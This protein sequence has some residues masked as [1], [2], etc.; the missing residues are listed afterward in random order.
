MKKISTYFLI[1]ITTI[2]L[3][4]QSL[5]AQLEDGSIAEDWTL[6]DINGNSWNL[7]SLLNQNISVFLDF[8]AVWCG[9]CWSY[10]NSGNLEGLY[11][12][13]GPDGTNEVMVFY[14]EA[15]GG[16]TID[17]LNGIGGGT[18]GNWVA[19]T[20]YPIILT[21]A[22]APSYSV[23]SDYQIGYFP[24]IYRVCPNRIVKEVGQ[25]T[26]AAL[27]SSIN[28]CAMATA[29]N[30]P[31]IFE[32]S[33][34][35]AGCSTAEISVEIQNM[36]FEPLTACT[37]KAFN[38]GVEILSHNWTG[39][40]GI[41]DFAN[42]VIGDL[43]LTSSETNLSI[44]ITS[45]DDNTANNDINAT[46]K[47]K[48]NVSMVVHLEIKTDNYPTQTRW[49]IINETTGVE[50][51]DGGPYSSADKNEIVFDEDITL[52]GI[53]CYTFNFFDNGGDGITGSG[54]YKLYNAA[55]ILIS[56][57]DEDIAFKKSEAL[58]VTGLTAINDLIVG[59]I[60]QVYPNPADASCAY[61]LN[62]LA[63][64]DVNI[65][66]V[67]VLGRIVETVASASLNAGE[68]LYTIDVRDLNNGIYFI[69][70][71]INNQ[72]SVEKLSILH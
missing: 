53:G 48:D 2:G 59:N 10:H 4:T 26:T 60:T 35:T 68:H 70:T 7:Y 29:N 12:T 45:A 51:Y 25:A 37:I 41:Y 72:L 34:A 58:K 19:G 36:G 42:V 69:Q 66:V 21:H 20:P 23:V 14:I 62:L 44:E 71:T 40:L 17:Q 57:G 8:S 56:D 11:D 18:Q 61:S 54:Y 6:T 5:S 52:P 50:I 3:S 33:G 55:G 46:I 31:A 38:D 1:V 39:N 64:A 13:Y 32:Y 65:N 22:G 30:D 28:T 16:S 49:Q 63:N 27:Y 24:T 67:D 47:Y 15:D 9:P 43:D